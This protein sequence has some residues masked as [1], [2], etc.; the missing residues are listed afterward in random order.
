NWANRFN[1]FCFLD[2]QD[3]SIQPQQYECLLGAGVLHSVSSKELEELERFME[4]EKNWIF[5]PLSYGLKNTIHHFR[6][7]KKDKIGFPDLFFFVPRFVLQIK[8]G[9]LVIDGENAD[10][11]YGQII[12]Q[13]TPPA[14]LSP[15][16]IQQRLSKQEYIQKV[17][18]LQQHIVR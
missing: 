1:I 16:N 13:P 4:K 17:K 10:Q 7:N 15:V 14:F 3:Y 9:Q 8:G 11:V 5:G 12:K 18:D 2:N 6:S